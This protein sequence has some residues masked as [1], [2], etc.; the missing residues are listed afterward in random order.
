[1]W[2]CTVCNSELTHRPTY[3]NVYV[4]L[5]TRENIET[6]APLSNVLRH[7]QNTYDLLALARQTMH[8]VL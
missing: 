2:N 5:D 4:I 1:M 3:R 7:S 6:L 8:T